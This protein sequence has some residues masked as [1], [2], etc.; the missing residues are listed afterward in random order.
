MSKKLGAILFATLT[1]LSL[2]AP[3]AARADEVTNNVSL[4]S[5]TLDLTAY[6]ADRAAYKEALQTQMATSAAALGLSTP[7][8]SDS[9]F[10]VLGAPANFL[11]SSRYNLSRQ[12][13]ES[14]QRT[15]EG[16]G[17]RAVTNNPRY[18]DETVKAQAAR[19]I[20]Q[21]AVVALAISSLRS[22]LNTDVDTATLA[23]TIDDSYYQATRT[24]AVTWAEG[25]AGAYNSCAGVYGLQ[26]VFTV[27]TF[28]GHPSDPVDETVGV[29][30]SKIDDFME[31]LFMGS[32]RLSSKI[33]GG[34]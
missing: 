13:V 18:N 25:R 16:T 27:F 29:T 8:L 5:A 34:Q 23:A 31:N 1:G 26:Q 6:N 33:F 30:S 21:P 11:L 2:V 28:L 20:M 22:A 17:L 19:L 12:A 3:A 32:S 9:T 7:E 14:M 15:N 10:A 24:L 4:C